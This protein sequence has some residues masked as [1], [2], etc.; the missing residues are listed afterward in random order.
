MKLRLGICLLGELHPTHSNSTAECSCYSTPVREF[1]L[2]LRGECLG[3][4]SWNF[5]TKIC[6][7]CKPLR[8]LCQSNQSDFCCFFGDTQ[9]LAVAA[10][11]SAV[12]M[13]AVMHLYYR[14]CP[15]FGFQV[16]IAQCCHG[17]LR[18]LLSCLTMQNRKR[19]QMVPQNEAYRYCLSTSR[20]SYCRSLF[21]AKQ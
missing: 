12:Y 9:L 2:L 7:P 5:W 21:T 16:T 20:A 15:A 17:F 14:I 10:H 8:L 1:P 4:P 18:A 3:K 11:P 13:G 19:T 6:C